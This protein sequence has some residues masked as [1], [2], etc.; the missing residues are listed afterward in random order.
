M[1]DSFPHSAWKAVS[2]GHTT[3]PDGLTSQQKDGSAA[4]AAA[5]AKTASRERRNSFWGDNPP[6]LQ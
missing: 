5:V 3:D 2:V 6:E 4:A 1:E